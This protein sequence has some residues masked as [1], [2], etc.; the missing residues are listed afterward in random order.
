MDSSGTAERNTGNFS[1]PPKP[2][3]ARRSWRRRVLLAVA[4]LGLAGC[5]VVAG[6][7]FWALRGVPWDEIADGSI[8]P[9]VV[10]ESADGSPLVQEGPYQ[11]AYTS[12]DAFP[13]HLIDA[14]LSIEDRRFYQHWGVD[15]RGIARAFVR[16][17]DAGEVVQ[18]GSTITQQ[19]IKI[20]YLERDRT[21]RRKIQEFVIAFWLESRLGKDQIL[22]RY[23]NNIYLGAGATGVPA[24][25]R[26]Y[27]DKEPGELDLA[28]S[29][30][31]A[32]LIIAPSVLNPIANAERAADRARV[33]L[34]AMAANGKIT[35][36]EAQAA[37]DSYAQL[38]PARPA[39]RSG[40][41]FADW[42]M[43]EA[44]EIAADYRGTINVATTLEPQLQT[45]ADRA[46]RE[47]LDAAGERAAGLQAALVALGPDGAVLAMVG[48]RDYQAS[49]F[50]RA[51]DARRQPGSTFKTFVLF[52][53]LQAGIDP[54][55]LVPD[56]PITING[57][58]PENFG[59]RYYGLVPVYEAFVRSLNAA[60]VVLAQEIGL[61]HV[62][63]A[64]HDLGIDAELTETPALALGASEVTLLDLTG[65]YASILA[66]V[67]PV[68]PWG[69]DGFRTDETGQTFRIGPARQPDIDISPFQ[70]EMIRLL[71][72]VVEQGT[73]QAA[74]IDGFAAGKTGTSQNYRDAWFVGFTENIVAGVW[75]GND[76][77][78]PMQGVTG[79]SLPAEIWKALV[80]GTTADAIARTEAG[81]G[82]VAQ[83][84]NVQAC[85]RAYRSFRASDCSY[86]PFRG[87]RLL[88]ER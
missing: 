79:G 74:R 18:G 42:A 55:A 54:R 70:D 12:L 31:I 14:V 48:G 45:V 88:C 30:T 61:A 67:A 51:V 83:A 20:S 11:G 19:L 35:T 13:Q 21:Y 76:D 85:S 65:A 44:R 4:V 72:M 47:T 63:A 1:E 17:L 62:A 16:N 26:I 3:A 52:A 50:N 43:R 69:I 84:C 57:W 39:A 40:S 10:L 9:V 73:G 29:A 60:T 64:A 71:S 36:E 37:K 66:G 68:E 75:V 33:V 32:G 53:A 6:V 25:A 28:E 22:T 58:T 59:G 5:V 15:W 87:P 41:W 7:L 23:L 56:E 27:Y 80:E 38:Q 86:Q 78:T 49:T 34:D 24:A 77:D 82:A 2:D 46:V 81:D 8:A